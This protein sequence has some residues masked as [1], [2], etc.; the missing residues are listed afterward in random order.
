M[1]FDWTNIETVLL[2]MDGTLL[3][4]NFDSHFWLNHLPRVMASKHNIE[5]AEA[6]ARLKPLFAK[7]AGTLDWY[8]IHF[9]SDQ[10]G[11]DIMPHKREVADRIAYRHTAEAFLKQCN[12]HTPDVRLVTNAHRKVLELKVELTQL[13]QYFPHMLCSHELGYAKE[14]DKFWQALDKKLPFN[15]AT[16]LLVDDNEAVLESA[17][18]HGIKHLYSIAEPDSSN[19]RQSKSRFPM[20]DLFL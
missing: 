20:I 17:E 8:C 16:T 4:L 2:D 19:T 14:E 11:F 1:Q 10:V 13:D 18:R 3:D 7:H 5:L 12:E 9:W 15:P 6:V